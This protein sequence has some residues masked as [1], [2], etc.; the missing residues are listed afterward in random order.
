MPVIRMHRKVVDEAAPA[1]VA[2]KNGTDK[3]VPIKGNEACAGVPIEVFLNVAAGVSV[4]QTDSLA[5]QPQGEDLVI[6]GGGEG[7]GGV[8]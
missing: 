6:V 1:V 8:G 5:S 2:A 4:R 3:P 7:V